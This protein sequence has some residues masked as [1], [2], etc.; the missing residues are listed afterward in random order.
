[1]SVELREWPVNK[2]IRLLTLNGEQAT[3]YRV[4][5]DGVTKIEAFEKAGMHANIP[6]VRVWKGDEPYAEFCQHHIEGVWFTDPFGK[7]DDLPF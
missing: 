1:M 3:V 6:Y 2:P 4:G 5:I 7:P